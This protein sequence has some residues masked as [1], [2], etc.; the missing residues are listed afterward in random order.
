MGTEKSSPFQFIAG[1]STVYNVQCRVYYLDL[2][3]LLSLPHFIEK[4]VVCV[5]SKQAIFIH[6][7]LDWK[8]SLTSKEFKMQLCKMETFTGS[9]YQSQL[10]PIKNLFSILAI[11]NTH[12]APHLKI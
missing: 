6:H 9:S 1:G 4:V 3:N 7:A 2:G 10:E 11:D 8:D 12:L 5:S